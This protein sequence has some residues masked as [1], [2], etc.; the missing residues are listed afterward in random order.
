MNK[1]LIQDVFV[2][3]REIPSSTLEEII[4][5]LEI[6]QKLSRL[7]LKFANEGLTDAEE[8]K[9]NSLEQKAEKIAIKWEIPMEFNSDPR[10]FAV[11]LKLPSGR[12]N[13]FVGEIWG[14]K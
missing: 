8:K 9:K 3:S 7:N 1:D 14:L 12:S 5:L 11:E 4:K 2:L 13:S 10:G 6:A